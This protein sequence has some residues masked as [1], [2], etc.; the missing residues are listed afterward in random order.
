MLI[1][2]LVTRKSPKV[3]VRRGN[4]CSVYSS[5][6]YNV[7]RHS[8]L[9]KHW[10]TWFCWHGVFAGATRVHT[11]SNCRRTCLKV[12]ISTCRDLTYPVVSAKTVCR[13]VKIDK[14]WVIFQRVRGCVATQIGAVCCIGKTVYISIKIIGLFFG[15]LER[16]NKNHV[17]IEPFRVAFVCLKPQL[18]NV[19]L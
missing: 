12:E 9:D 17:L 5:F 13:D 15:K 11:C 14:Q 2:C 3:F 4:V 18:T 1:A 8:V 19:L 6:F 7:H 10:C 16:L